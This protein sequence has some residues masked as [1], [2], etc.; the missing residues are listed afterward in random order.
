MQRA[1]IVVA[2]LVLF[3]CAIPAAAQYG[4]GHIRTGDTLRIDR[5]GSIDSTT[6]GADTLNPDSTFFQQIDSATDEEVEPLE[7]DTFFKKRGG[8]YGGATLELT[9]LKPNDLDPVLGGDLVLIG[10]RGYVLLNSWMIG[11]AGI[12]AT[13]YDMS[14]TYD[15]F[16]F[17][18]G[19]FLTGY[20]T[21]IFHGALSLQTSVLLGAGGLEMIRRRPD[22]G[23]TPGHEILERVRNEDFFCVRPGIAIGYSPIQFL[24]FGAGVDYLLPIG[25]DNVAD[26]RKP[27][28]GLHITAALGD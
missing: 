7:P 21:K 25:G 23:G 16:T 2:A 5:D 9:S 3:A 20:D 12:S 11:G 27:A 15:R 4:D 13:I 26:L 28:F 1:S 14:P 22:L 17:G 19:G 24:Q 10:L 6:I 18:Y 8:F